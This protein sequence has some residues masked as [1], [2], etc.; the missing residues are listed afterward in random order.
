MLLAMTRQA[1]QMIGALAIT[2]TAYAGDSYSAKGPVEVPQQMAPPCG[3]NWFTG[4]SAGQLLDAEEQ[5]YNLHFGTERGCEGDPSTHA[6]FLEVGYA[7]LDEYTF[8]QTGRESNLV[9]ANVE[10]DIIPVT[11]NYKY[12][13]NLSGALN[14][15]VGAGAGV[16][17]VDTDL[18]NF[19]SSSSYDDTVF[20]AQVFAGLT[21]NLSA[22]VEIYGGA[23]Y[24]FMDDPDFNGNTAI[25]DASSI[26]GDVLL[27]LGL[28]YNF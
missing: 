8:R 12:E 28:R 1:I 20:Y 23:R 19:G 17:F 6:F 26:D 16:A 7:N 2:A 4:A 5:M 18:N 10:T 11:L 3:W 25:E 27:E 15:Y 21:Y 9:G 14:F 13:R 22:A 24:I